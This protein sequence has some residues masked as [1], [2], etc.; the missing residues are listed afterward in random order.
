MS[1]AR[2]DVHI[3]DFIY[4]VSE[5]MD[6]PLFAG[7]RVFGIVVQKNTDNSFRFL[8]IQSLFVQIYLANKAL[9]DL[10]LNRAFIQGQAGLYSEHYQDAVRRFLVFPSKANL[11]QAVSL[12]DQVLFS[13]DVASY[14]Y[15][16]LKPTADAYE[17]ALKEQRSLYSDISYFVNTYILREHNY[18]Y[19]SY[20]GKLYEPHDFQSIFSTRNMFRHVPT[21]L[22]LPSDF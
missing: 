11:E 2:P 22:N 8:I 15:E 9:F 18:T 3:G 4:G 5:D 16:V 20:M 21:P 6:D 13:C 10:D 19:H 1:Q 7:D 17:Q 14:E 12:Y